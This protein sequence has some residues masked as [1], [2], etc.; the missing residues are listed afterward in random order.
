MTI[1][2][3][4]P[5]LDEENLITPCV[6]A[7]QEVFSDITVIDLGS[8]DGTKSL[9]EDL[10]VSVD[11]YK[12]VTGPGFTKL[13]NKYCDER[14][15]VFWVD[16]DEVWPKE[17]LLALK[18]SWEHKK[19]IVDRFKV[20]WRDLVYSKEGNLY[21]SSVHMIGP[22]LFKGKGI[23]GFRRAWPREVVERKTPPVKG[24]RGCISDPSHWCW[25]GRGFKRSSVPALHRNKKQ[26]DFFGSVREKRY[27]FELLD[28]LPFE[29]NEVAL[30]RGRNLV[31][32][33]QF[34]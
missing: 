12:D 30:K 17:S 23:L 25:H 2:C 33:R 7:L 8:T 13:K 10:D 24:T 14:E 21:A 27:A 29:A 9:L 6:A 3:C 22:K 16:G 19:D 32:D 31:P 5:C 11:Y 20:G 15:W 1:R 4:V 26:L 28:S 34:K 18:R